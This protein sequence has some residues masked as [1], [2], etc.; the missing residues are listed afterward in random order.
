[1]NI[2]NI[3]NVHICFFAALLFCLS[4]KA[5]NI[6]LRLA[7]DK[8]EIIHPTSALFEASSVIRDLWSGEDGEEIEFSDVSEP[9]F[10]ILTKSLETIA[11][12]RAKGNDAIKAIVKSSFDVINKDSIS[13]FL[14]A[15]DAF[16]LDNLKDA[17]AMLL[18]DHLIE[19]HAKQAPLTID[20]K[21]LIEEELWQLIGKYRLPS[22][23]LFTYLNAKN[24]VSGAKNANTP[25][26][27]RVIVVGDNAEILIGGAGE[28]MK[29]FHEKYGNP[30]KN[31]IIV[32]PSNIGQLHVSSKDGVVH[33]ANENGI[34]GKIGEI[35]R[36]YSPERLVL[37]LATHGGSN[38]NLCYEGTASCD[39]SASK[40]VDIINDIEF[41]N[42]DKEPSGRVK[43]LLIVP[44]SCHNNLFAQ[45]M[46]K[47]L[48]QLPAKN[49]VIVMSHLKKDVAGKCSMGL[50]VSEALLLGHIS[51]NIWKPHQFTKWVKSEDRIN[52]I[53]SLKNLDEFIILANDIL[54]RNIKKVGSEQHETWWSLPPKYIINL[55]EFE[56]SPQILLNSF[57]VSPIKVDEGANEYSASP[58][59]IVSAIIGIPEL[60][61]AVIS[62]ADLKNNIYKKDSPEYNKKIT[63]AIDESFTVLIAPKV[64][65]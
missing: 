65:Q 48:D 60:E 3:L 30:L 15:A 44:L 38:G 56:L 25:K 63:W 16:Y 43:Q 50:S 29:F 23:I 28:R 8:K 39:F 61:N 1:M 17:A 5:T 45:E 47:I 20:E 35:I 7:D 46:H 34:K 57:G 55:K 41:M 52:K 53:F 64:A 37:F 10:K 14:N 59:E 40:M 31:H 2:K 36:N 27:V 4:T 51:F 32:S 21:W 19:I 26:I 42:K 6:V 49:F 22:S 33:R 11:N 62:V 12:K 24:T 18:V 58:R 13:E 9:M 54:G